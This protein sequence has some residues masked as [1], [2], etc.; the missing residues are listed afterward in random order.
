MAEVG[1]IIA[2]LLPQGTAR[3]SKMSASK[4]QCWGMCSA[5]GVQHISSWAAASSCP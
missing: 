3:S 5:K 1:N 2:V 4:W